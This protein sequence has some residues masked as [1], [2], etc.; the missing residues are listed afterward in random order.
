M[1]GIRCLNR[2]LGA[3]TVSVA[4]R[5][6]L[7]ERVLTALDRGCVVVILEPLLPSSD[8]AHFPINVY[9]Y[10]LR[11]VLATGHS[12]LLYKNNCVCL[13]PFL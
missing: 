11:M 8:K 7:Y 2:V 5:M 3:R 13:R 1:L 6:L 9:I 10:K 4:P 12:Y